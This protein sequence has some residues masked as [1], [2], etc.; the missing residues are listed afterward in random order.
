VYRAASR[1]STG[2][3][4]VAN[5]RVGVP[6]GVEAVVVGWALD[7][8]D[9]YIAENCGAGD[10]VVT[11]DIPLASR[12]L[13]AGAHA[14]GHKGRQFTDDNIGEA[15]GMRDL[16]KHIRQV[17]GKEVG[18]KPFSDKDRRKFMQEFS[19]LLDSLSKS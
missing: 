3:V 18:P 16:M 8:A 12:A 1:R 14:I 10:V 11:A 15:M 7:A 2:V 6:S 4:L 17:T 19:Q 13:K 5:A 9:N